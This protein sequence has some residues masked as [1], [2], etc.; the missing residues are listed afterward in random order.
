MNALFNINM[1]F[2]L[3]FGL[4][5]SFL[6]TMMIDTYGVELSDGGYVMTRMFGAALLSTVVL[7][8]YVRRSENQDFINSSARSMFLYWILG[9]IFILIAQ[10]AGLFNWVAWGTFGFHTVFALWYAYMIFVRR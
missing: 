10:L 6:P 3:V 7:L 1:V 9:S 5:F 8:W 2:N 4:G